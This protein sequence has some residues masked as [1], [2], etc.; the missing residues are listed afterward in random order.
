MASADGDFFCLEL[1][2]RTSIAPMKPVQFLGAC[3]L[4]GFSSGRKAS[5]D[6]SSRCSGLQPDDFADANDCWA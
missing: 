3:S 4:P 6:I 5:A 2:I 1:Y